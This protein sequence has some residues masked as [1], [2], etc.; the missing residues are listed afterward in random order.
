M[1]SEKIIQELRWATVAFIA[2]CI[3]IMNV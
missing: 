1:E 2:E 3:L